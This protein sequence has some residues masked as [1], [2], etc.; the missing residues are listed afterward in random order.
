[1]IN[2][3]FLIVA[4]LA[5]TAALIK[6]AG[7]LRPGRPP[8]QGL[9]FTLFLTLA[10]S[11]FLLSD[12]V[13]AR[14]DRLYPDLGRL[15]SN[16]TT[17]IAAFTILAL[18]I[19]LSYPL[20]AARPKLRRRLAGLIACILAMAGLFTIASPLPETLGD[21]GGLYQTRPV[22]L[23]YI[24][25]YIAFL[26]TALAELLVLA[27]RYAQLARHRRYLHAGLLLMAAG[28]VLGLV[29][30][31]EKTAYVI[32]QAA[33]LPPPFASDQDCSSLLTPAQCAFSITLPI[34]A[35]L[36]AAIGA[37]LP[38]WGAALETPWRHYQQARTFRALEPLWGR[39]RDAFP[40]ITL[41]D[42]ANR[43]AAL[44]SDLAFRLY[45]RVIE[46]DD[47]RLL[48][49]PYH[50]PAVTHAATTAARAQGLHGDQ[51]RA[52]VEAAEIAAALEAHDARAPATSALTPP[53]TTRDDTDL[54]H[55]ATWL[56]KVAEAFTSSPIARDPATLRQRENP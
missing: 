49:R 50:D 30:L 22:L 34:T 35:V 37:T 20:P 51:L 6:A 13:Q 43:G 10:L 23:G 15:L 24:S 12:K 31:A 29:Y 19:T 11:C 41:P 9:L 33:S 45:R 54:S 55:E 52:T 38:V 16:I 44:H 39:L 36:L 56:A 26:G 48:L 47:A 7:A 4:A 46:I 42:P 1:M 28:A 17:M 14:E 8:G 3:A 21:F 27:W 32:T 2:A 40:Q 25:I 53:A 18:L 5:L